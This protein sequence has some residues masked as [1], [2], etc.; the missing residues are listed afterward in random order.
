MAVRVR[1][2]KF[3]MLDLVLLSFVVNVIVCY[4]TIDSEREGNKKNKEKEK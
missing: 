4:F 1:P 2:T 3:N